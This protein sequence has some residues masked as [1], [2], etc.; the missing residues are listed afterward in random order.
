MYKHNLTLAEAPYL[1]HPGASRL[2][3]VLAGKASG[4]DWHK[5]EYLQESKP[6]ERWTMFEST[7]NRFD[8]F[9]QNGLLHSMFG[10]RGRSLDLGR[11]AL[12]TGIY[13]SRRRRHE[14]REDFG[15]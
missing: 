4:L 1:L 14:G 6:T 15:R 7:V 13:H 2:R 9:I 12:C 5:W 8:P 10:Q 11:A 3:D